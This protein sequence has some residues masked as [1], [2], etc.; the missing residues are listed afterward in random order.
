MKNYFQITI[1]GLQTFTP[2]K[3]RC[4]IFNASSSYLW[5]DNIAVRG[6][7][8]YMYIY[9]AMQKYLNYIDSDNI[10]KRKTSVCYLVGIKEFP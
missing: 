3:F 1:E 9:T 2:T 6:I 8:I 7:V 5:S 10:V 4:N